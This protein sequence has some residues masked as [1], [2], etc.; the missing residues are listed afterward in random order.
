MKKRCYRQW[1]KGLTKDSKGYVLVLAPQLAPPSSKYIRRA[2]LVMQ[3]KLGRVLKSTEITHHK[4]RIR[5]DDR[6]E[7][8]SLFTRSTHASFHGQE[9][10]K[11]APKVELVCANCK[12]HF[13]RKM[14][15]IKGRKTK[16]V[17]CGN[18][19]HREWNKRGLEGEFGDHMRKLR[20]S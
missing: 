9:Q 14:S 3:K 8:L 11:T 5:D 7:N 13:F 4:N 17:F 1:G 2:R 18:L 15:I 19:C 16:D 10:P 20:H 6:P 12:N